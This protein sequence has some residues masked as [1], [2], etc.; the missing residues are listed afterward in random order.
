MIAQVDLETAKGCFR[1]AVPS[2]AS[3]GVHEAL[4]LRDND[5]ANY[6]GKGVLTAVKNINTCIAPQLLSSGLP[7][8]DQSGIDKFMI[9][10]DGT[11]NKSKL[12]ANAILGV[13]LA[14]CKAGAAEK[15]L[16]LYKYVI[17][18]RAHNLRCLS[19]LKLCRF[20]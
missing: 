20:M 7:V 5:K 19:L 14:V 10:M 1:A 12:G 6:H 16:P 18:I 2:G 13:S 9:D 17:I 4:E 3:T 15:G 11:E 8:T